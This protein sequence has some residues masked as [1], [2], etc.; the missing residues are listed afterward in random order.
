MNYTKDLIE[1][2][3]HKTARIGVLGLGYVGLPLAVVFA[4]AGF[5]VTGIDPIEEKIKKLQQGKSYVLDVPDET[6][7]ILT[8][9]GKLKAT[10]DFS[11]LKE[12]DAVSICVPTPL[13]KTGDPDLSYILSVADSLKEYV[14]PA[15]PLSWNPPPTLAPPAK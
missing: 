13:R 12:L 3:I 10:S 5:E 9:S 7:Q 11:V 8:A 4:Q 15:W 2:F 14:H 1:K 6:I